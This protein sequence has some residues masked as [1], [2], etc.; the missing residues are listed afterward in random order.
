MVVFPEFGL[1]AN[2]ILIEIL[3]REKG[4]QFY[5]AACP[6]QLVHT[7]QK[8]FKK[9]VLPPFPQKRNPFN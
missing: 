5:Q 7:N 6:D 3:L 4:Q 2:A 1:P 9:E 8:D